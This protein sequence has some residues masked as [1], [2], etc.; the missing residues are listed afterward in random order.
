MKGMRSNVEFE[1][2]LTFALGPRK[3]SEDMAHTN[4]NVL[5]VH[6]REHNTSPYHRQSC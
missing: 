2:E 1:C 6:Q 4:P 5:A 3:T